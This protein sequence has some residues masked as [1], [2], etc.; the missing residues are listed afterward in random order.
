MYPSLGTPVLEQQ[1]E[2]WL[3]YQPGLLNTKI[4]ELELKT[5][6]ILFKNNNEKLELLNSFQKLDFDQQSANHLK[7]TPA[8]P[9]PPLAT[10]LPRCHHRVFLLRVPFLEQWR[11]VGYFSPVG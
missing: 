10:P 4:E 1:Q 2:R 8:T 3:A 5:F 11:E 9:D 7:V 6:K